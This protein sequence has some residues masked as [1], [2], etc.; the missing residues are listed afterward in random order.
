MGDIGRGMLQIDRTKKLIA[1]IRL[2]LCSS[3]KHCLPIKVQKHDVMHINLHVK[4]TVY[5][6]SYTDA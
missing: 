4:G 2:V 3:G 6:G 5:E 1:V